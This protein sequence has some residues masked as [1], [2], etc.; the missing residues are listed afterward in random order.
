MEEDW[1]FDKI[2][3]TLY[4]LISS[5][6]DYN[7]NIVLLRLVCRLYTLLPHRSVGPLSSGLA[8]CPIFS[9]RPVVLII[10]FPVVGFTSSLKRGWHFPRTLYHVVSA[11]CK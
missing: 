7:Y 11:L 2:F 3:R 8:F 1:I 4:I 10:V 5:G 9:P 6:N